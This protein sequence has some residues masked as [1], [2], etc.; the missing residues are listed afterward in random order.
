MDHRAPRTSE[1]IAALPDSVAAEDLSIGEL[2]ALLRNRVFGLGILLFGLPN[3]LPMPPGI[4]AACGAVLMMIGLPLALGRDQLWLPGWVARRRMP[5]SAL[6]TIADRGVPWIQRFERFSRP[7]LH[8]FSG[9]AARRTVGAIVMLLG[10]VLFLPFP[11]LGNMP[12][13]AAAC[14]LGLALV[15]RDGAMVIVGLLASLVAL[16]IT[17]GT[18][19]ALAAGAVWLF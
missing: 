9:P 3:L 18:T 14:I 2:V 6:R 17:A 10:L 11:F 15:E 1:L 13:G 19:W 5:R 12:P 8:E 7:R 16:L 4:P